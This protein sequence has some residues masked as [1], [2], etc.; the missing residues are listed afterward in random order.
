MTGYQGSSDIQVQRLARESPEGPAHDGVP[1]PP[2]D[3]Q[4]WARL[5]TGEI[6]PDIK[7]LATRLILTRLRIDVANDRSA[8]PRAAQELQR[9]FAGNKFAHRDLAA[10]TGF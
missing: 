3:D 10:I 5:L 9:F 4:L 6:N 8:L 1:L 2:V 7:T